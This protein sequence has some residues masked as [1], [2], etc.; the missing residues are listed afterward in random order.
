MIAQVFY[1][2]GVFIYC[3]VQITDLALC[4]C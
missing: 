2:I 3:R 1:I 4:Y